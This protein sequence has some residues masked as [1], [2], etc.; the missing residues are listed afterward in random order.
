M[1]AVGKAQM[2]EWKNK[3]QLVVVYSQSGEKKKG[4]I[5]DYDDTEIVLEE[6]TGDF[7]HPVKQMIFHNWFY[8]QEVP[9]ASCHD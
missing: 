7:R 4:T 1:T 2:E 5:I 9:P 6:R 3:Q 8:V